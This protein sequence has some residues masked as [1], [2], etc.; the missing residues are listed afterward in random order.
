MCPSSSA[1]A[2]ASTYWPDF[3]RRAPRWAQSA[4]MEWLWRLLMEPGS[5][6]SAISPP[7]PNSSGS[8]AERSWRVAW[9]D[10]RPYRATS[11]ERESAISDTSLVT[12]DLRACAIVDRIKPEESRQMRPLVAD[13]PNFM[14][15]DP[16]TCRYTASP[17]AA[18][19]AVRAYEGPLL[20]DLDETLYLRNSTEDFIDCARPGLLALLLLRFLDMLKPWRL[21][22]GNG[23]RDNWRVCAISTLFPW[24]ARRWRAKVPILADRYLN[25]ELKAALESHAKPP[26]IIVTTGFRSIA[27]PLLAA[28]GFAHTPLVAPRMYSFADRRNGK[29]PMTMRELGAET[30]GCS[31]FITNSINDLDL[32]QSCARPLQIFGPTRAIAARSAGSTCQANTSLRSNIRVSAISGAAY[33]RRISPSGC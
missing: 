7:T 33:S 20:V 28:M 4:G 27:A 31:L 23:T 17:D 2:A 6:G 30:V 19:E 9:Y 5:C 29:L 3:I 26:L 10:R 15:G 12:P 11:D 24:T 18:L 14:S 25:R 22:G 13:M 8:P 32:L 21:T 16:A 1:S